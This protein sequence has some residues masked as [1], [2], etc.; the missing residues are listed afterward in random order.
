MWIFVWL[1]ECTVGHDYFPQS[2]RRWIILEC[3]VCVPVLQDSGDVLS[4]S[5]PLQCRIE[6][7]D[8]VVTQGL[9]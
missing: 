9:E 8:E 6:R 3:F 4:I 1:L 2:L 5:L 7:D